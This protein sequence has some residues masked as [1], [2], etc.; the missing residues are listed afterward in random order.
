VRKFTKATTYFRKSL[1]REESFAIYSLLA[2]CNL[3]TNTFEEAIK[4]AKKTLEL[5]PSWEDTLEI[6]ETSQELLNKES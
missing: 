4:N 6:L 3:K 5:K 2:R 1:E